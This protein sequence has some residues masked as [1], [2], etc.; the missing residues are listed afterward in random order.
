MPALIV[1]LH[2]VSPLTQERSD[3]IL[4]EL[5]DLGVNETS[6]LVIPNHHHRAPIAEDAGFQ[7]WLGRWV[8]HGHE[9]VLHGFFHLRPSKENDSWITRF[10][11]RVYTAGEGEFFDLELNVALERLESGLRQLAFL[12]SEVEGFVAPAWL[13]GSEARKA[14]EQSGFK[15]TT[16]VNGI[17]VFGENFVS[18]RSLV[19]STRKR[20][21]QLA[22]VGWNAVLAS[23]LANKD[24]IRIAIHPPDYEVSEVWRQIKSTIVRLLQSREP[25]SYI[26]YVRKY[27]LIRG[28]I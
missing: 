1:D 4:R 14:V 17:A 7:R 9:P 6:L 2:D 8:N 20:W 28:R 19:W 25:V 26:S 16:T 23:V 24:P 15:Y 21:R 10:S 13:L 11:T 12:D 22:S 3:A 5:G 27:P 18:S